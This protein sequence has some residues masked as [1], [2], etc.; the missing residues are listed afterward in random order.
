MAVILHNGSIQLSITH[1]A[2]DVQQGRFFG[3]FFLDSHLISG[4]E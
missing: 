1:D 2:F 3:K 4:Q